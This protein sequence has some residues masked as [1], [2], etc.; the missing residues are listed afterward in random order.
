MRN[1]D[2][3]REQAK[4]HSPHVKVKKSRRK[5]MNLHHKVT[6]EQ[7]AE[8]RRRAL[9]TSVLLCANHFR[10]VIRNQGFAVP[11]QRCRQEF[12]SETHLSKVTQWT[13]PLCVESIRDNQAK[14]GYEQDIRHGRTGWIL[15][16]ELSFN[17]ATR[18]FTAL[19]VD[20]ETYETKS[21]PWCIRLSNVIDIKQRQTPNSSEPPKA[22]IEA[23]A[24][25]RE[26]HGYTV[27]S[28]IHYEDGST[29][30]VLTSDDALELH[31]MAQGGAT[32]EQLHN[33]MCMANARRLVR[34]GRT[35]TRPG[36][37]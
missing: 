9:A 14:R 27:D 8:M 29:D 7:Y 30:T 33:Y 6:D 19:D 21:Q 17:R 12:V 35:E 23:C 10:S 5:T 18:A 13:C 22:L 26:D 24:L 15:D 25:F 11:C 37:G 34:F 2:R 31:L 16:D 32:A 3:V 36:L 1:A 28:T 20:I 4:R